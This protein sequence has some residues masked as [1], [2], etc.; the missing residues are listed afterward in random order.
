MKILK[1]KYKNGKEKIYFCGIKIRAKTL[2][3]DE[4]LKKGYYDLEYV[5]DFLYSDKKEKNILIVKTDSIGDYVLMRNF[6][7]ELRASEKYKQA[8]IT[9]LLSSAMKGIAEFLDKDI[10]EQIF[11][12]PHPFWKKSTKEKAKVLYQLFKQG[13]KKQYDVVLFPNVNRRVFEDFNILVAQYISSNEKIIH[14]GELD[15]NN[16][17]EMKNNYLF[18]RVIFDYK[19]WMNF[20]IENSRYFFEKVCDCKIN[21]PMHYINLPKNNN[22]LII[23]NPSSQE[24]IKIWHRNNWVELIRQLVEQYQKKVVLIGSKD[25]F[26]MCQQ[27]QRYVGEDNCSLAINRPFSEIIPLINNADLFIGNDSACFHIAVS[28][29]TKAICIAGGGGYQRFTNYPKSS[30]YKVVL[31]D[32]VK[33]YIDEANC[34]TARLSL[35]GTVN[36]VTVKQVYD[37]VQKLL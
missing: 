13:L 10:V 7:A 12:V 32:E 35:V 3:S 6:W 23:I 29:K 18:T 1:T 11:Y 25:E 16:F 26:E 21:L 19:A 20:E 17:D 31:A 34:D 22:N 33:Q 37:A 9:L 5:P 2:T 8:K 15:I 4:R 30:L 36:S 28:C 24:K 14:L 27:I